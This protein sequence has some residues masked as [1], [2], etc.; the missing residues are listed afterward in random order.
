[1]NDF[2]RRSHVED[3]NAIFPDVAL[4]DILGCDASVLL[5]DTATFRSLVRRMLS[6]TAILLQHVFLYYFPFFHI[7]REKPQF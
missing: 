1:M 5:G 2:M 7:Y 3:A 6:S 4:F